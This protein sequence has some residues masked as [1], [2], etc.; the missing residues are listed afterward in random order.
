MQRPSLAFQQPISQTRDAQAPPLLV[1]TVL[2][3]CF[4]CRTYS[5]LHRGEMS[6]ENEPKKT[7]E[8][9]RET[10][11][12]PKQKLNVQLPYMNSPGTVKTA[13]ERIREAA[14]PER[15][16]LDFVNTIL[17][18][19][20]GTGSAVP[21][22]LKR[23]GFVNP[24]GSPSEL[25]KQFRNSST[26]GAAM[27]AAI[28]S[29]FKP[30]GEVR[31]YFYKLDDKE[32]LSLIVQVTG[33]DRTSSVVKQILYTINAL[34]EFANFDQGM[35]AGASAMLAP[36]QVPQDSDVKS[37]DIPKPPPVGLGL[38][39]AYTIN[40]NLPATSDQAVFNA[41]FRSLKEHLL[42]YEE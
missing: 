19:K 3:D 8:T 16:H 38:N 20:G 1:L 32:L 30:L 11:A 37:Q 27:A 21:P 31:E 12:K 33:A 34:K 29:S 5:H 10:V 40:L 22:F 28:R 2:F 23:L 41:I 7:E 4:V 9:L 6:E 39:L 26:G 24:D 15:V 17:K 18:M 36:G 14:L 42:S 25:Y 35:P 13:L